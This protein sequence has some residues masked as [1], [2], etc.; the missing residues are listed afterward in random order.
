MRRLLLKLLLIVFPLVMGIL[1]IVFGIRNHS[2]GNQSEH[3]P[4]VQGKL[5]GESRSIRKKQRVHISY[6]YSVQGATYKNSRVN[7]QD[8]KSSKKT[9]SSKYNVG[10][11]LPVYYNPENPEQSVLMP[12]SS[13][14]SLLMK[15]F[16]AFF[17]FG[18][19]AFF[20]FSRKL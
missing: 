10:D 13:L 3:W 7:F 8:D 6:E 1:F 20:L 2:L 14:V 17:C 18:M 4:S 19:S 15:L 5:V 12:G 11:S 9:I 16:G